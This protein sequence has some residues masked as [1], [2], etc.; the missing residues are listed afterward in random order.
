MEKEEEVSPENEPHQE[1]KKEEDPELAAIALIKKTYPKIIGVHIKVFTT[2]KRENLACWSVL[3]KSFSLYGTVHHVSATDM[4]VIVV[5]Y[6]NPEE[7]QT[8]VE[9]IRI[10][11][12]LYHKNVQA[13]RSQGT[14]PPPA[15]DFTRVEIIV[16]EEERELWERLWCALLNM[17]QNHKNKGL[18]EK[19]EIRTNV[20]NRLHYKAQV[21][22]F[23]KKKE[24]EEEKDHD[25]DHDL[26]HDLD[27]NNNNNNN[28]NNK[29]RGREEMEKEEEVSPENEPHQEEKK[30]EGPPP[31]LAKTKVEEDTADA[32]RKD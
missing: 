3:K 7:A 12:D 29:K 30:E 20:N 8:A 11:M 32:Q 21:Q 22:N 13:A 27:N 4:G 2:M 31:K 17:K 26:D 14:N 5:R 6:S 9:R 18:L 23:P 16:G 25:H 15:L 19:R 10:R 28:N 24:E 1:E